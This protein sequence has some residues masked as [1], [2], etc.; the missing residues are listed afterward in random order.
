MNGYQGN[1][2]LA[3]GCQDVN[4]CEDPDSNGCSE[5]CVNTPGSYTCSCPRGYH[6]DGKK[7]GI[8]CI[9]DTKKFPVVQVVLGCGLGFLFFIV[10]GSWLFWGMKKRKKIQLKE[11]FFKQNGGLLLQQQLSSHE[12]N[13]ESAR[14]FTAEELEQA[15]D[16]YSENRII[17]RGGYGTVYKG[18]LPDNR[19][20]A[21]KKSKVMDESQIEQ[22]INEVIILSQ[23]IHKNVVRILGCCLETPVPLLVYE[24]VPNGT[25]HHHIHGQPGSISWDARLR[26]AVETANALSYLH[27]AT[28][29][30]I[31]HRDVKSANILVDNNYMAKVSDFGASRLIP[32]DRAQITTL[33]Q[34][35]LGY[36]DPEY[37]QSGQLTEKSDVYSFGVVLA[38]LLTGEKPISHSRRQEEQN[39]AIYFLLKMRADLLFDILEA[40]VKNEG[41]REQ[42]QGVAEVAKKCLKL[43]GE[44]RPTMNIVTLELERWRGQVN[45]HGLLSHD[46]QHE[47]VES[48]TRSRDESRPGGGSSRFY[49]ANHDIRDER[50]NGGSTRFYTASHH[51]NR[52]A[53][54]NDESSTATRY[55]TT[56][57]TGDANL[58][59]HIMLSMAMHRR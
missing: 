24:Y 17:G 28:A 13:A 38:E 25:V 36:L 31:F 21:I 1:P 41:S 39:L 57:M 6:G 32:L 40:R 44:E 11:K 42:L 12:G 15:T 48:L 34:G 55:F 56:T 33:V 14:I 19:V 54:S 18:I 46:E 37:F 3:H 50:S 10:S 58:D 26:I 30:P 49:T 7:V 2:Y 5:I 22:F 45:R 16:N 53:N 8:G 27:S 47:E 52:D 29:R 35:T 59:A 23:V 20:V 4:E 43:K 51:E 9:K